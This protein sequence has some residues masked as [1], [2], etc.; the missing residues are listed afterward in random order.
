MP[1]PTRMGSSPTSFGAS[2][3]HV[4]KARR[5]SGR[6]DWPATEASRRHMLATAQLAKM[7]C[8]ARAIQDK[9]LRQ[10]LFEESCPAFTREMN[11][12][13]MERHGGRHARR[14]ISPSRWAIRARALSRS[15]AASR[16]MSVS[17]SRSSRGARRSIAAMSSRRSTSIRRCAARSACPSPSVPATPLAGVEPVTLRSFRWEPEPGRARS[18][19]PSHVGTLLTGGVRHPGCG[20]GGWPKRKEAVVDR[21]PPLAG[22][23]VAGARNQRYLQLW[24]GAA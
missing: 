15:A 18:R 12:L 3:S 9:R 22:R 10:D 17:P 14:G 11:R 19:A 21:R 2:R 23:L 6:G 20:F 1:T 4:S 7:E 24:T 13:R 8:R 5:G 16:E